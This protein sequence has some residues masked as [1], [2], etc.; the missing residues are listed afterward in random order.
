MESTLINRHDLLHGDCEMTVTSTNHESVLPGDV[1]PIA[2][3]I[4][5]LGAES[6]YVPV[7]FNGNFRVPHTFLIDLT[8]KDDRPRGW[9]VELRGGSLP[10]RALCPGTASR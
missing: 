10:P 4:T 6:I 5:N 7:L 9:A 2:T 8:R 3:R 1:I